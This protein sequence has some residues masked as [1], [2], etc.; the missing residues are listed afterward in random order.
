MTKRYINMGVSKKVVGR[1]LGR[2][3]LRVMVRDS[4][5]LVR[6]DVGELAP[7]NPDDYDEED[8]DS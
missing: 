2:Y 8:E 1:N 4:Y 5:G 3:V 6:I 7:L